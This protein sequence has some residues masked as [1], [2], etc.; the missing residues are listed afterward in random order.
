MDISNDT[1]VLEGFDGVVND[2]ARS[3]RGVEDVEICV[4][5]TRA[6]IVGGGIGTS[7]KWHGMNGVVLTPSA[8]ETCF[9]LMGFVADVGGSLRLSLLVDKEE[10]VV[11]G[12]RSVKFLPYPSWALKIV[13]VVNG[14]VSREGDVARLRGDALGK[15]DFGRDEWFLRL[16]HIIFKDVGDVGNEEEVKDVI[17][18]LNVDIEGFVVKTLV[19]ESGDGGE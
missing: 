7:V 19:S 12:V 11:L 16:F 10:G 17:V 6:S 5:R 8:L 18:V 9:V 3:V 4:L 2:G 14:R 13:W 15:G 1:G